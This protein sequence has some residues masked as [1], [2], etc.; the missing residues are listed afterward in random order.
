M[1]EGE[2]PA[3][4]LWIF[5]YFDYF[6]CFEYIEGKEIVMATIPNPPGA[7]LGAPSHALAAIIPNQHET[8]LARESSRAL[9]PVADTSGDVRITV[10]DA[11][12]VERTVN[13]PASALRLLFSVL[14]EMARGNAVSLIPLHAE[15]TTQEAADILNVSRPHLVG[16]LEKGEIPF[17]KVGVQRRV[18]FR[19]V[20]EYK[21]RSDADRRSALDALAH[22]AQELRLG[23]ER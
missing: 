19:D 6:V 10:A 11:A 22:Q 20:M 14:S 4:G 17:R 1:S 23:Y 5:V 18:Q 16:L 12:G 9:G 7:A 13:I 15:I 2:L 3:C 8:D 21:E